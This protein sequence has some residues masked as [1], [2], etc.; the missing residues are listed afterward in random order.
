[1][2]AADERDVQ[3]AAQAP[4]VRDE[5][6]V[7]AHQQNALR[8]LQERHEIVVLR[9]IVQPPVAE[10]PQVVSEN[11][12]LD[13][14][15]AH[16]VVVQGEIRHLPPEREDVHA[17]RGEERAPAGQVDAAPPPGDRPLERRVDQRVQGTSRGRWLRAGSEG[18]N[19][20]HFFAGPC[21]RRAASSPLTS[22]LLRRDVIT[23]RAIRDS[24]SPSS[25]S[26]ECRLRPD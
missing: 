24:P 12:V 11:R 4:E 6:A 15:V 14:E 5:H 3:R 19:H 2:I 20:G 21:R 22:A 18:S 17:D 26:S 8:H 25:P 7:G 13:E 1:M 23:Q 16:V 9:V 10:A